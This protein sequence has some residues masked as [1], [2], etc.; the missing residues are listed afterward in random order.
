MNYFRLSYMKVM[1]VEGI[2]IATYMMNFLK[3]GL[4]MMMYLFY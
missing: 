1:Q 3:N 4:D 2:I